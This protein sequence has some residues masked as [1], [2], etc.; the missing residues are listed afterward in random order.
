[1]AAL[2]ELASGRA[3][4]MAEVAGV[5]EGASEGDGHTDAVASVAFS[6]DG[7]NA[8]RL[9]VPWAAGGRPSLTGGK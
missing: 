9:G 6:P 8:R 1:M 5:L 3:D 2:R 4:L 7:G